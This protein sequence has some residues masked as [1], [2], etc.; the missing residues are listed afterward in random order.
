M[1]AG[2]SAWILEAEFGAPE[3]PPPDNPARVSSRL[4]S[5]WASGCPAWAVP[6][7]CKPPALWARRLPGPSGRRH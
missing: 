7:T 3:R 4:V 6:A 5:I 2:R 1:S